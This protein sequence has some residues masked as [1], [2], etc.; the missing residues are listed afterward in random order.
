MPETIM[1]AFDRFVEE[2]NIIGRS[3]AGYGELE[4]EMCACVAAVTNDLDAAIRKLFGTRGEQRRIET[5]GSIM[6]PG[7]I[8]AGLGTE[9]RDTI[10]N[11]GWCKTVRNQYAHCNWYDTSEEGLCFVN[12]ERLAQLKTKIVSVTAHRFP[13]DTA[14]LRQQEAYFKYVQKCFWYLAESYSMFK[15]EHR[16]GRPLFIWPARIERPL[17]HN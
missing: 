12:L 5:A 6:T 1:P 15:G 11:M 3:L 13:I 10:A 9:Y 4:L 7:Y 17:K 2:G 8:S 16:H 14:L